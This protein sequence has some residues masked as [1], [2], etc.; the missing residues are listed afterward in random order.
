LVELGKGRPELYWPFLVLCEIYPDGSL[1]R[2]RELTKEQ[3]SLAIDKLFDLL[4]S[5]F[6][7]RMGRAE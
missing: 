7:D 5:F 6:E 3:N 4:N 2:L 1:P